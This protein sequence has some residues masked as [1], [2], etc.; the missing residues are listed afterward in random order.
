VKKMPCPS[1]FK[2]EVRCERPVRHKGKC[3][4]DVSVDGGKDTVRIEWKFLGRP[5]LKR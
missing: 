2:T 1:A 4:L 5:T 3:R